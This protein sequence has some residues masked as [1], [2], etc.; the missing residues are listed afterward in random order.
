MSKSINELQNENNALTQQL[1][2][3]NKTKNSLT[4]E[5]NNLSKKISE[6]NQN[7]QKL[8]KLANKVP[9]I[10]NYLQSCKALESKHNEH[11]DQSSKYENI[12]HD[13]KHLAEHAPE[14]LQK[15]CK[16]IQKGEDI[17]EKIHF[18]NITSTIEELEPYVDAMCKIVDEFTAT[19]N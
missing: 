14:I 4:S 7:N 2:S 1:T 15:A 13:I 16:V 3:C 9:E 12:L 17:I 11:K 8:Q 10:Q 18:P 6:L 19:S 5:K